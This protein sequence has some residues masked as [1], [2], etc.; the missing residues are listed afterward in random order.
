MC[1]CCV[2]SETCETCRYGQATAGEAEMAGRG[3]ASRRDRSIRLAA[4]LPGVS[5]RST[6]QLLGAGKL[7]TPVGFAG[8]TIAVGIQMCAVHWMVDVE[9]AGAV[10]GY[11]GATVVE[12]RFVIVPADDKHDGDYARNGGECPMAEKTARKSVMNGFASVSIVWSATPWGCQ[13][14]PQSGHSRLPVGVRRVLELRQ[15]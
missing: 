15:R 12:G 6:G 11:G 1:Y 10:L 13:L 3:W 8:L 7:V 14:W 9:R 2:S 4:N 5:P